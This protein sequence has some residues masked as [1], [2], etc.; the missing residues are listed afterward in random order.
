MAS[1]VTANLGHEVKSG[2]VVFKLDA[3]LRFE[4]NELNHKWLFQIEFMEADPV[5]DDPLARV[6]ESVGFAEA[7]VSVIRHYFIPSKEEIELS[8]EEEFPSHLVDTEMGKEEVYA[9]LQVLP[10]ENPPGFVSAKTRTNITQVD[11]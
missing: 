9:N 5:R 11:V 3:K 2:F 8:F 7:D 10:L 6:P 1:F 4:S